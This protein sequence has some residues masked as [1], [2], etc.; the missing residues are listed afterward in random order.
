MSGKQ[1]N[2]RSQTNPQHQE[3]EI[4]HRQIQT[5]ELRHEISNN[6]AF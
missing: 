3:K 2:H 5:Y 6:V 4:G 1:H